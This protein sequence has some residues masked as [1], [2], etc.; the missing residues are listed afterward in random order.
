MTISGW[1][2]FALGPMGCALPNR[3]S[4]FQEG[5]KAIL[6]LVILFGGGF[7]LPITTAIYVAKSLK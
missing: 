1:L 6:S 5:A 4:P 7:A 2:T 3:C